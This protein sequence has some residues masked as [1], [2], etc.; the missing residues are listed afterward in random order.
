VTHFLPA[1]F[2]RNFSKVVNRAIYWDIGCTVLCI[3]LVVSR[4]VAVLFFSCD[5]LIRQNIQVNKIHQLR[6]FIQ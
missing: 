4:K 6:L 3:D 1:D 5:Q 2:H